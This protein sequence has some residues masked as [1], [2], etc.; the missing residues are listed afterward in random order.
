MPSFACHASLED[1]SV[2]VSGGGL[3]EA[4][5]AAVIGV[6]RGLARDLGPDGIRLNSITPDRISW[7]MGEGCSR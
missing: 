1:R 5:K 6:P 2:F 4:A 7:S 3:I